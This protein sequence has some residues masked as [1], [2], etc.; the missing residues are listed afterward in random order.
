MTDALDLPVGVAPAKMPL[1]DVDFSRPR[2]CILGL[3]FDAITLDAA[4]ARIREDAFAGRRCFVSTPNLNFA[5]AAFS[6]STFRNSVLRSDLNLID[7]M[8]L[9]WLARLMGLKVPMRVAGSDVFEAL[10]GH[11]APAL[12]IYLFGGVEGAAAAACERINQRR[13]GLR[14]VGFDA[15]GNGSIESMSSDDRIS[16][17]NQSGAQFVVVALGARK[18]QAWIE[19]NADRL[20]APILSHLGAV[21]N[22]AAGTLRRAP[23]WM[24]RSGLEWAWRIR[25]EPELWRRYWHDGTLAARL[26]FARVLPDAV[27]TRLALMRQPQGG[28]AAGFAATTAGADGV[29]TLALSGSWRGDDG[30]PAFAEALHRRA[31]QRT[32]LQID[33]THVT[34]LGNATAALLLVARGWFEARDG[35]RVSG[36]SRAVRASLHRKMIDFEA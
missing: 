20:T 11:S 14:C 35:F 31:G 18:G 1:R 32:A 15:P 13:G 2:V 8:P 19:R 28:T 3:P 9:V 30:L 27:A 36:A 34:E 17:I 21:M 4:V 24:Q 12:N 29:E 5:I 16:R 10:T 23:G 25:E 6:D 33:L 7:G 26:V 22:F